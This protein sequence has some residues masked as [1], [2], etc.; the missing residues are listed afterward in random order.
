MKLT[1]GHALIATDGSLAIDDVRSWLEDAGVTSDVFHSVDAVRQALADRVYDLAIVAMSE[2]DGFGEDTM[3]LIHEEL[4]NSDRRLVAYVPATELENAQHY[5]LAGAH[6]V[7]PETIPRALF[8]QRLYLILE[9]VSLREQVSN[10]IASL[11]RQLQAARDFQLSLLPSNDNPALTSQGVLVHGTLLAALSVGGDLY[12]CFFGDDG[13]FYFLIGDVSGKGI[14]A[15]LSMART[16]TI[17]RSVATRASES[18]SVRASKIMAEM[19]DQI[20]EDNP[21]LTFVTCLLGILNP[22]TG[23]V[24]IV[25]GGHVQPVILRKD[26]TV[27]QPQPDYGIPLGLRTGHEF[28]G[29]RLGMGQGDILCLITDGVTD[30]MNLD[31]KPF[32][33]DRFVT[34][35][36]ELEEHSPKCLVESLKTRLLEFVNGGD[37]FD[38]IT[39]FCVQYQG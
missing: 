29:S 20:S 3:D 19:N 32:G 25:N 5:V 33:L 23:M 11:E 16:N 18:G 10:F 9:V 2:L 13:R 8:T 38:D 14:A 34:H 27:E 24:D 17:F 31:E 26:G 7:L 22:G 39:V 28:I 30:A 35:L 15:A 1:I 21:S 37:Q 6:D 12:D 4:E 36:S